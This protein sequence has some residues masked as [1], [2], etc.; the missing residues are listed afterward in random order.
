MRNWRMLHHR[1]APAELLR[2][3]A[4]PSTGVALVRPYVLEA[5]ERG[6]CAFQKQWDGSTILAV[7]RVDR[8][9]E[10]QP[11]RVHQQMPFAPTHFLCAVVATNTTHTGCFHRL[12][13]DDAGARLGFA[14]SAEAH[15]FA[16]RGVQ[17]LPGSILSPFPP[18]VIHRLPRWEVAGEQAPGAATPNDVENGVDDRPSTMDEW[19]ASVRDR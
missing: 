7:R 3:P 1:H 10:H 9:V 2:D 13:I 6:R 5:G 16:E 4:F 14:S 12:A 18:L 8:C 11:L 19:A 17:L 15:L